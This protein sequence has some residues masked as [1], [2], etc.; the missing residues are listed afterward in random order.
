MT[1]RTSRRG[2]RSDFADV[3]QL[4]EPR[5]LLAVIDT[6][7]AADVIRLFVSGG[8]QHVEVN[9]FDLPVADSSITINAL[10]G[11]DA[12]IVAGTRAG[13]TI[14]VNGGEGDDQLSNSLTDLDAAYLATFTF[15]GEG[16]SDTVLADNAT[17][18]TT[19][20]EI[21]IQPEG[22]VK[23]LTMPLQ[24]RTIEH[25]RYTDSLGSNRIGFLGLKG[26]ENDIAVTINANAGDDWITNTSP[27]LGQGFWPTSIGTGGMTINGGGGNDLLA[28]DN[29]LANGGSFTLTATTLQIGTFPANP[30]VLTYGG[31]ESIELVG[32]DGSD[33]MNLRG[34]PAAA[35]LRVESGAGNDQFQVG[36]GD[37]DANGFAVANT[38]LLAGVGDDSILFEDQLDA[39][40]FA[41]SETYTF[42][43]GTLGKGTAGFTYGGF[44]SQTLRT[45]D[46]INGAIL[47]GNTVNFNALS[48]F[49]NST[50]LTGGSLRDNTVNVG[51]G[52]LVNL[53]GSFTLNFNS[54][55]GVLAVND[56]NDTGNDVYVVSDGQVVKNPGAGAQTIAHT[57]ASFVTLNA[58]QDANNVFV[59][60]TRAGTFTFVNSGG[61][62]DSIR[63]GNGNVGANLLGPVT[64]N[65]GAGSNELVFNNMNDAAPGSQ[66]LNGTSFT[67]GVTHNASS[68]SSVIIE[69][70]TGG[71]T[72]DIERAT[73]FTHATSSSF[74][75]TINIGNGNLDANLLA[76][77]TIGTAGQVT[78]DDRLDAGNDGYTV[79]LQTFRKTTLGA[80]SVSMSNVA[81]A[82]LQAN[83]GHNA[84]QVNQ[85]GNKLRLF[86]NGGNDHF[87]VADTQPLFT[88]ETIG[89]DTGTE[90]ASLVEPLGDYVTVNADAGTPGDVAARV[91]LLGD[92]TIRRLTVNDGG[93]FE[94]PAGVVAQT[95]EILLPGGV[96]DL[97][98]GALLARPGGPTLGAIR[99]WLQIGHNGGAWNGTDATQGSI[100]SSLADSS[101]RSDGVGYGPGSQIA[102]TSIG[103][104]AIAPNDA[105][106]RYTL[107]GD[108]DL[109]AAVNLNDFNRLAANFGQSNKQWFEGDFTYDGAVNLSDFNLLAGNFGASAS[110]T[111][112]GPDGTTPSRWGK[113][114]L[115]ELT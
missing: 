48:G 82:I 45:A 52:N 31:C 28:I 27:N 34:K 15:H 25:V 88:P 76:D 23:N 57:G 72:L 60:S 40:H 21:T 39:E 92:D 86:G 91:R 107:N 95:G 102:P 113:R 2:G 103:S 37:I 58:N 97:A 10:G 74:D 59:Q 98:G 19:P 7:N 47:V 96:I 109:D 62:S 13:A 65:G 63:L 100:N 104:F 5:R 11:N 8:T 46:V 66:T 29:S 33:V 85:G 50:T 108:A 56:Q 73:V 3:I 69:N 83:N 49:I 106:V 89:I 26:P 24:Y 93:R 70:G 115:D 77:V 87:I 64:V 55:G 99:R 6:T 53:S 105:L 110:A 80:R 51:N 38:T 16:G 4:L 12:V 114:L 14:V 30:G 81:A 9:G 1:T 43:N 78:V 17:D 36:G 90:M 44:D 22:I 112:N 101:S 20:A 41:E 75:Q 94:I 71:G 32:A 35:S 111:T 79:D 68:V 18:S 67:D 42:N 54:A 61:G 84:I